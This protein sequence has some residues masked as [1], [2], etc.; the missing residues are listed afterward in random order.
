MNPQRSLSDQAHRDR[1]YLKYTFF[2]V[3]P[4]WRRLTESQRAASKE[5]FALIVENFGEQNLVR[6]YSLVGIR[7]DTDCLLWNISKYLEQIQSFTS[8]LLKSE[9]GKYLTQ[10]Y[11]YLALTRRSEYLGSHIH[12]GQDGI[13][14]QPPGDSKYL[15]V[16]PFIKKREWY[17]LPHEKRTSMMA[18]HFKIGHEYPSVRIHTG[19]S[20]GLDDQEFVLAFET[21]DPADFLELVMKLRSSEASR[22]TELETPIFTCAHM[23]IRE[24]LNLLG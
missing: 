8:K 18:Q 1:E 16:Y 12:A 3:D 20:F 14:S 10:P 5:E 22:Y 9:L 23:R 11:S 15:F 7:G 6:A 2:K 13:V 21:D 4:Q 24:V 19:Y 17:F